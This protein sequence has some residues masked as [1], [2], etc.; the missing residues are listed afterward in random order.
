MSHGFDLAELERRLANLFKVGTVI[1]VDTAAAR[2]CVDIDGMITGPLPWITT[3]AGTNKTWSALEVGEQVSVLS[4]SGEPNNGVILGSIYSDAYDAP[5]DEASKH[6]TR[7]ADGSI[8][9]YDT[10]AHAMTIDVTAANGTIILKSGTSLIEIRATN[11]KIDAARV[12]IN[13]GA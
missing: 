3:R 10:A 2:A 5:S 9:T 8:I 6:V 1:S 4:V 12:D 11:I 7:Y 13:E